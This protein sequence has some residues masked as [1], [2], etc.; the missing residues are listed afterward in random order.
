MEIKCKVIIDGGVTVVSLTQADLDQAKEI[1]IKALKDDQ[2]SQI[3]AVPNKP[4]PPSDAT[5][6]HPIEPLYCKFGKAHQLFV[7]VG[8]TWIRVKSSVKK[9][10]MRELQLL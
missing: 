7:C 6:F 10:L 1:L 8:E 3:V 5:H 2:K 4:K 9:S